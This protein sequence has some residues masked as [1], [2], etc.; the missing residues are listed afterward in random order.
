MRMQMVTA[1][2]SSKERANLGRTIMVAEIKR[3]S[4]GQTGDPKVASQ[5]KDLVAMGHNYQGQ[6]DGIINT[7]GK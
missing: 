7:Y 2:R 4:L 6:Q 3:L 1:A 5:P